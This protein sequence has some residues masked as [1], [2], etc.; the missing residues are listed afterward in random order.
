MI[1]KPQKVMHTVAFSLLSEVH[2]R[3]NGLR[4]I[5]S[6]SI[7]DNGYQNLVK[8]NKCWVSSFGMSLNDLLQ[9]GDAKRMFCIYQRSRVMM[10]GLS[11]G[12]WISCKGN[13]PGRA[14]SSF[15][16]SGCSL[17]PGLLLQ[18]GQYK[19]EYFIFSFVLMLIWVRG[20]VDL[21]DVDEAC[22]HGVE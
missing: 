13:I 22:L 19:W 2:R 14:A 18:A 7:T 4:E 5:L 15:M 12:A 1:R 10:R 16:N 6:L 3:N 11:V 17:N 21:V 8:I 9:A 20:S